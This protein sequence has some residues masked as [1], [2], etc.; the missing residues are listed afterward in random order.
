MFYR[1]N[2]KKK[3]APSDPKLWNWT[4]TNPVTLLHELRQNYL[5]DF[6]NYLRTDGKV[7]T[8]SW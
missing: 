5:D 8:T 6:K 2:K 7:L 1:L 3:N 4:G